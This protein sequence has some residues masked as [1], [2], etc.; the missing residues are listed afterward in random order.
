MAGASPARRQYGW[1]AAVLALTLPLVFDLCEGMWRTPY[2]ISETVALLQLYSEAPLGSLFD[3]T[4]RSWY[5]PLYHLSWWTLWHGTGS[6]DAALF[7]F[8][9]FEITAVLALVGLFVWH[10][11]PRTFIDAAAATFALAVL[12]G[13]PGFRANLEIP[14]L[15]TLVG[16]ALAMLV[17]ILLEREHRWWHPPVIVALML[18]AVGFKEQGLVIVPLVVAAW[19]TGA[20]GATR[21]TTALVVA[22]AVAYLAMRVATSGNW[23]P[24]EQD[25]GLGFDY[26]SAAEA[27]KRFGAFPLWIYGYNGTSTVANVLFSEPTDGQFG[28]VWHALHWQLEAWEFNHVMSS[29]LLT[30]L[31]AWWGLRTLK[32]EAGRPWSVESRA[33]VAAVVAL[34]ASGALGFNYSRDRLGGMAVVFYAIAAYFSVRAAAAWAATG[35]R[36]RMV[37]ACAGLVILAGAWQLRAIGTVEDVRLRSVKIRREWIVDLQQQRTDDTRERTYQEILQAM[38]P[39]GLDP[40]AARPTPYPRWFRAWLGK[41]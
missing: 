2:P 33:L 10:L 32:R 9:V 6:L 30:V 17:W 22:G 26:L 12:V 16:M 3:P 11:R 37:G 38:A 36:M 15:M 28:V 35:A 19:W 7:G 20:P 13:T 8:K 41:L 34:A 39:Q 24:F 27:S 21:T 31:V 14:L 4:V 18:I 29:T 5:R 1:L 23:A 40:S 25:V